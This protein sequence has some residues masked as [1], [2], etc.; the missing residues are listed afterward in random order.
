[1][2]EELSFTAEEATQLITPHLEGIHRIRRVRKLKGG[3][4]NHVLE[5][6]T[7]GSPETIVAKLNTAAHAPT[8]KREFDTLNW[9]REHTQVPVP[10]P[11]AWLAPQPGCDPK[12][13]YAGLVLQHIPG[14]NLAQA[15]LSPIGAKGFQHSLA[16]CLTHLHSHTAHQYGDAI[17]GPRFD[18]WTDVFG[19]MLERELKAVGDVLPSRC[20]WVATEVLDH[21]DAWLPEQSKPQ[22]IHSDLWATNILVDDRHPDRPR[23][24]ALIDCG[25][26]FA[27]IE[28]ELAYLSLFRTIDQH[29]MKAYE[30]KVHKD[31]ERRCRVYW[32]NAMLLHVRLFGDQYVQSCEQVADQL[33]RLM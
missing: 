14:V 4:V 22:L 9:Y 8:L 31:F 12:Q 24:A 15:K 23:L 27:D 5:L 30:L 32:L 20:R 17:E 28:Y 7:D 29:F 1:M 6:T 11:L 26:T 19:P 2:R 18:K 10:K 25:A 13:A 33:R 3:V 16:Q 21:L